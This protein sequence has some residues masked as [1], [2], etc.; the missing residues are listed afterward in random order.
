MWRAGPGRNLSNCKSR[1][2]VL[3]CMYIVHLVANVFF[4]LV[5]CVGVGIDEEDRYNNNRTGD[6]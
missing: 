2:V 6:K 3:R 4:I 1:V 5:L